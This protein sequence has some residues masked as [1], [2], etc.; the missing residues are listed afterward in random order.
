MSSEKSYLRP[1]DG[2]VLAGVCAATAR[3]FKVDAVLVRALAVLLGLLG[4]G[5]LIYLALW[6]VLPEE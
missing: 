4:V 6:I 2:R 5:V 1:R 3:Q